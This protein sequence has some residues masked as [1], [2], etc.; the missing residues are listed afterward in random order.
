MGQQDQWQKIKEIVGAALEHDSAARVEYLDRAC[1]DDPTLRA[2]VESLLSAHAHAGQLSEPVLGSG[3]PVPTATS[4]SI[5][6]YR[7]IHELGVGGMGRVWLAEQ[8][9]PVRRRVALK[10]IRIGVFD[11]AILHR[12]EA[13]RQS[14]AIMDHPAIAKVF[15]A[16]ATQDGQPYFA[17][18]YVDGSPITTYCDEKKLSI[19]DRLQL[20]VHVCGGVQHAHQ[21]AII[22]RDLKPSNI[23]VI[24]VDG[25]PT[26][27]IIDFGLAKAASP[28]LPGETLVTQ[29]GAF[30]GTPG[31]MSPEQADPACDIDTRSDVYSLGVI[32][33][34]LLTGYL[35]VEIAY[36]RNQPLEETL[37]HLRETEP[38]SPSTRI[39]DRKDTSTACAAA[40]GTEPGL[41]VSTL[42]G[43]LDWITL[44]ALEKDR[45]RR[46]GTPSELAADIERYLENRPVL[47]RPASKGYRLRKYLGRNR[48]AAA[49]VGGA[50]ALLIAFAV[51]QTIELRRITRER[52][53]ANRI[54][55]FM[56]RMF[57][58]SNPSEARGNS[59]TAREI[60]D[61]ASQDIQ[62]GMAKDPE[63]QAQM[64]SIM[65]NT[66]HSL[67][68]FSRAQPLAERAVDIDRRVL[69]PNHPD[70]LQSTVRLANILR[71]RGHL[72]EAEKMLRATLPIEEQVF[73]PEAPE[74]L[75]SMTRMGAVLF[76]EG[77]YAEAEKIKRETL[78]IQERVLGADHPDTLNSMNNLANILSAQGHYAE[79]EKLHRETLEGRRR[80]LGPDHPDTLSSMNNLANTLRDA[81]Q[82]PEAE[83]LYRETVDA[84]RRILGHD[85]PATLR[86][87]SI[88]ALTLQDEGQLAEAEKLS[89]ETLDAQR[90]VL[91]PD[92]P[93]TLSTQETLAIDLSHQGR[94]G[95]AESLCRGAIAAVERTNEPG[96][97]ANAWYNFACA[98]AVGGHRDEA[99]EYLRRAIDHGLGEPDAIAS[100]PDLKSLQGDARFQALLERLRHGSAK[101]NR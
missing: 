87:M 26:P 49:V 12:F 67:G 73:G 25:K 78:T 88:L 33:Y 100:D 45:A 14:I 51:T 29:P 24:E 19:R 48:A 98:A 5:G 23:L 27:R 43:D 7:L 55:T 39:S 91:G 57:E 72:A 6:P 15:D 75:S 90:R 9:H 42:R 37:R 61:K 30:L 18:E 35:P 4:R 101:P 71:D 83:R 77:K 84:Q 53:R 32:L 10:L 20:F 74:T 76:D 52:D 79:A 59:V 96:G 81:G 82:Y 38:Q 40:R 63:L 47:A 56:T 95:E 68:V 36:W 97:I 93:A 62:S 80:I 21:K 44:K 89:R 99:I 66:Y 16:G 2:E 92:H 50:L 31:Y 54:T 58:V 86:A 22:H 28:A 69:G 3:L 64:M 11:Q 1:S 60:L 13:E 94:Y 34:E 17:M 65:A 46:Y 85:H 41:L 70:T 8:T